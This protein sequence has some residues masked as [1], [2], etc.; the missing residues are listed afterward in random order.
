MFGKRWRKNRKQKFLA[1]AH[2]GGAWAYLRRLQLT[3]FSVALS[4]LNYTYQAFLVFEWLLLSSALPLHLFL[5]LGTVFF[6][7]WSWLWWTPAF[8]RRACVIR[9]EKIPVMPAQA[10][11]AHPLVPETSTP[12]LE[13]SFEAGFFGFPKLD[14]ARISLSGLHKPAGFIWREVTSRTAVFS[15]LR[16][17]LPRVK[18][19]LQKAP[20]RLPESTS[21]RCL[22]LSFCW[23]KD[24]G[25][26]PCTNTG[27]WLGLKHLK[28]SL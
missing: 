15:F 16:L 4:L 27:G 22:W 24:S 11:K 5:L 28:S 25:T 17:A 18:N 7:G 2:H 20:V 12:S 13:S 10:P 14:D 6:P 1:L 9:G 21:P 3:F 26:K 8:L 19:S 23:W